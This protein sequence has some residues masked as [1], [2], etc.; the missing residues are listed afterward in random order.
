[1]N[2]IKSI[3]I[4]GGSGYIGKALIEELSKSNYSITVLC[5]KGSENKIQ[6]KTNIVFGDALK[7][8]TFQHL[9]PENSVFIQL[10]GTPHPGP[11]KKD[12]F[13]S[14]DLVSGL[15]SVKAATQKKT[16]HFIYLSV[17]QPAPIMKDYIRVRS[18]VEQEI[19]LSG[20]NAT[21]LR[22]WYVLGPEHYW[23]SVLIPFYQLVKIFPPLK[24][25]I[26]RFE[27]VS[28]KE[29]VQNIVFSIQNPP[30]GIRVWE[31]PDIKNRGS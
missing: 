9:I 23:P 4:T 12:L 29:I 16:S 1:M 13:E 10:I 2:E 20:I 25:R 14:I 5:R 15:E 6:K 11:H 19:Q 24:K 31:V 30:N 21:I 17:A 18:R 8:E 28:L 27:F 26:G 22:P 3:F 7:A